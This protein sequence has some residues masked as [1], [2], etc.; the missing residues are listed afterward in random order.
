MA[1]K[2]KDEFPNPDSVSNRDVLQRL[3]F[4][5]QA[6]ALLGTVQTPPK[7]FQEAIPKGLTGQERKE[8]KRR[9][10]KARHST[11]CVDLSRAYVK[12]M[13][14]I[15]QKTNTRLYE[16]H[17]YFPF[18]EC[19]AHFNRDPAVKRTLCKGCNLVL[20]PG[21]SELVRINSKLREAWGRDAYLHYIC[22][23]VKP[24][25][26]CFLYMHELQ[27]DPSHTRTADPRRGRVKRNHR[28][29]PAR[30]LE[31]CSASCR[32]HNYCHGR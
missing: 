30:S 17:P 9:R 26:H 1:K 2:S 5:Y 14:V 25:A 20:V 10:N 15:G 4:L 3:N 18:L 11:A 23:I 7:A 28:T 32:R 31:Y 24:W 8:E 27:N 22:S 21:V 19:G 13:K 29:G 16:L 12:S 6:S